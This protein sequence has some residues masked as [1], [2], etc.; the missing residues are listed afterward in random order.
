MIATAPIEQRLFPATSPS[1]LFDLADVELPPHVRPFAELG[2][3]DITKWFGETSGGVKTYLLQKARYVE[4]RSALRQVLVIPGAR[5]SIT[6]GDGVRCYRLRGPRIPTQRPYRFMLATRSIQRIVEHERPDIIEVGSPFLVPWITR[7]A[8]RRFDVPLVMFFHSNFPRTIC[9]FP[10]RASRIRQQAHNAVWRYV[11]RLNQEFE[12]TI[13][14]S[15]FMA[16]DLKAHGALRVVQIPLGVDLAHFHPSR[17]A[18][19]AQTR[20][21]VGLPVDA[22]VIGFVGRFAREK[23]VDVLV[24]AWETIEQRTDAYL[25]LVGDGPARR[26]LRAHSRGSRVIWIPYQHDRNQ[27]ANV[28]AALDIF[29]SP[30]SIE[31][32][33]LSALEAA[34]SGTPVISADRGGVSEQILQSGGGALFESG[35][36]G[37]LAEVAVRMLQTPSEL[38]RLGALGRA[39]AER[40]HS[41][42]RVFDRIFDVYRRVVA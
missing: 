19:A 7:R 13:V 24:E 3:L 42:S 39:Y 12:A 35:D 31:T 26:R 8:A 14:A 2:V 18:D 28:L 20:A 29:V 1:A 25:A 27:L 37:A 34:A 11:R 23:E 38:S 5:D 32:F 6:T 30:G 41:W 15:E 40:E 22:P 21:L 33:G 9:A 4:D 36:P 16:N 10:E 17:R